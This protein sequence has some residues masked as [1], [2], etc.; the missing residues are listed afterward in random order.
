M[1][2]LD[3]YDGDDGW[4]GPPGA[5]GATGAPGAGGAG[6]SGTTTVDFGAFPGA[7]D[8]SVAVTGQA[9]IVAG[10]V[11]SARIRPVATADHSADEHMAETIEIHAGNIVAATGFTVYALNSSQLNEPVEPYNRGDRGGQGTRLY[12]QWNVSWNWS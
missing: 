2:G 11:V 4:P 3:G 10:S 8:T 1:P 7:S 5:T 9:A 12:G 6:N